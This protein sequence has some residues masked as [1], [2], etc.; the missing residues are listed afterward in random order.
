MNNNI[1]ILYMISLMFNIFH[2]YHTAMQQSSIN[3]V[4]Q[5]IATIH[6]INNNTYY[7]PY[8]LDRNTLKLLYLIN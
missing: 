8:T 1:L 6:N 5:D 2:I 4:I 7:E 3:S